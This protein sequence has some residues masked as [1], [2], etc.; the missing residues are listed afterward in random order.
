VNLNGVCIN[1]ICAA[2]FMSDAATSSPTSLSKIFLAATT[3][4]S[5]RPGEGAR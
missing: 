2:G 4:V 3:A 1:G 5:N